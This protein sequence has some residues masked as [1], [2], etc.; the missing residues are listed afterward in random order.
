[1]QFTTSDG[2]DLFFEVTGES[3]DVVLL[4]D[5][6]MTTASWSPVVQ[7]LSGKH[8]CL[9]HDFRGQLRSPAR[10]PWNV[11]QHA[12]DLVE[13]FDHLKIEQAH[14]AGV[15][16]GGEVGMIFAY[17]YPE[18]VRSLTVIAATSVADDRMKVRASAA[19]NAALTEPERLVDVVASDFS[20]GTIDAER[21]RINTYPKEFFTGYNALCDA[22]T[23]LDIADN[24]SAI[25]C[26]TLVIAAERDVVTPVEC[27]ERISSAIPAARLHVI[28]NAGHAVV[29]EKPEEVSRAILDFVG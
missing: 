7:D 10:G 21:A 25:R 6:M 15:S 9:L 16:Y 19:M 23:A 2:V 29:I 28:E 4:N 11:E 13:L 24:L 1:M 26:P 3:P 20:P 27:S 8:G 22:F 17:T 18:R 5:M 14:I 12:D